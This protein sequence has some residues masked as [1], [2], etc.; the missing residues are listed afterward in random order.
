MFYIRKIREIGAAVAQLV[1]LQTGRSRVRF[2]IMSVEFF[3]GIILSV[4][5]WHWGVLS[6]YQK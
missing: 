5:L 1:T 4:V 3:I 2:P 6:L